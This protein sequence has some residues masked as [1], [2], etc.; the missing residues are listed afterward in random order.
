MKANSSQRTMKGTGDTSQ[1]NRALQLP[2]PYSITLTEKDAGIKFHPVD[3][4]WL[5]MK[6]IFEGKTFT[7]SKKGIIKQDPPLT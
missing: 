7:I 6:S 4:I 2:L 1:S 3:E 5:I